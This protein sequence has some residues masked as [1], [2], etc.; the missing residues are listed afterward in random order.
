MTNQQRFTLNL[1]KAIRRWI[2]FFIVVLALSGLTA[3]AI[4]ALMIYLSE[5]FPSQQ[6]VVGKWLWKVLAAISDVNQQY[7]FMSY[8]FDWLA[9]AHIA[10]ALAFVGPLQDA[11]NNKRVI[12]F[13][14]IA[15]VMVITFALLAGSF[16][17]LPTW[18]ICID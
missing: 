16:R 4:E 14:R 13:G 2:V 12:Q 18:W 8:G 17:G 15:C 10:I 6:T 5:Y 11:V 1:R 7:P 3:L 9:F